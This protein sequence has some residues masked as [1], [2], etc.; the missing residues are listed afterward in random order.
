MHVTYLRN[1]VLAA[2][3]TAAAVAA[4]PSPQP[5]GAGMVL[6]VWH[7]QTTSLD[8][9]FKNGDFSAP[10]RVVLTRQG[11]DVTADRANGNYDKQIATLYG[12]V[13]MH[14]LNGNFAGLAAASVSKP[15]GP[16]TLTTDELHIDWRARVYTAVGHVHYIQEN[17]TVDA[18]RGMLNDVSHMLYLSGNAR[19]IQGL[20]SLVADRI[21]Y[22]TL[23][24]EAHAEGNVTVQFPSSVQPHFATPK[25]IRIP[26]THRTPAPR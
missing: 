7:L 23:T 4:A 18:D 11:G 10:N 1:I 8:S 13:V 19:V 12:D 9:N 22:N 15:R 21:A 25:P 20:R 3:I 6:G 5:T 24:G 26:G 16:S 2:A 14:D 17:T